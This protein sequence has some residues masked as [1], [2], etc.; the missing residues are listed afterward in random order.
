MDFMLDFN[1]PKASFQLEHGDGILLHGSCFSDEIL[2][3]FK[4]SGHHAV[5]NHYGTI[6]H[7][8]ILAHNLLRL[9]EDSPENRTFQRDDLFFSWNASSTIFGYGENK[10]INRLES[11]R[12]ELINQIKEAK[13]LIIT[14]GTSWGYE[15]IENEELVANCHKMPASTFQKVLSSPYEMTQ[16]WL[17]TLDK[18]KEINPCLQFVFTVSPVRHIRDGIVENN[19]SKARLI[20]VV[21]R[22]AIEENVHYFPS[23]ELVVDV[24]RDY[25]FF[26]S[27][28]VHPSDVALKY[29]WEKFEET[30]FSEETIQLNRNVAEL[31]LSLKHQS[32]FPESGAHLKHVK[33]SQERVQEIKSDF[34]MVKLD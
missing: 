17:L 14:F 29:V 2:S 25:R 27:D 12:D 8:T 22:L 1:I 18:L 10:L 15:L 7:P 16:D 6:F 26:K 24:L 34:P 21:Q 31:R 23:Y 3:Y 9:F 33:R 5:G 4:N 30:Y 28:M 19:L 11:I 13:V 20:E 32:L